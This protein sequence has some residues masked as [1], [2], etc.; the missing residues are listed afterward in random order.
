MT[1]LERLD[2]FLFSVPGDGLGVDDARL[3]VL[4]VALLEPEM[5]VSK[6]A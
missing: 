5:K 2:L 3:D 4:R 1:N 6:L